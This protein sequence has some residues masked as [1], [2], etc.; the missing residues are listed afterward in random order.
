MDVNRE[1]YELG[2]PII[3]KAGV[4]HKID[5]RE[6]P[7]LPLLDQMLKDEKKK[8]SF[9]FVFVDADK[10]NYL[11]YHKRVIELVKIGGVIGYD[12]TL[13]CGSVVAPPNAPLKGYIKQFRG[14]IME[15][16]N[17]LANDSRIEICQ[18][19]IGDGVT[20]CRRII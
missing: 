16:N 11:N 6:G 5:F 4:E 10:N 15:L 20:L 19:P 9:D 8:G 7:A 17:Y 18:I 2:L 1:Y 3:Q 13:W 12:N 14:D